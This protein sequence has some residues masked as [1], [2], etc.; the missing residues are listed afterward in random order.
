MS[1]R[2]GRFVGISIPSYAGSKLAWRKCLGNQPIRYLKKFSQ[3]TPYTLVA[4]PWP[5]ES[6]IGY[7]SPGTLNVK[8]VEDVMWNE[9]GLLKPDASAE[10]L[11]ISLKD[12]ISK[13]LVQIPTRGEFC[14]HADVFD[15]KT[16]LEHNDAPDSK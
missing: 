11:H 7:S 15:L 2:M 8:P 10:P 5:A 3:D 16:Y 12:P 13:T 4:M 9:T 1:R 14:T 6:A